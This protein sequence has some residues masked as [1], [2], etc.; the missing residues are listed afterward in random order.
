VVSC[1]NSMPLFSCLMSIADTKD[2]L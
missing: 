1:W 2:E